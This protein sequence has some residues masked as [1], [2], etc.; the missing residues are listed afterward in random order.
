[1]KYRVSVFYDK[2]LLESGRIKLEEI[3][4][5]ATESLYTK[6]TKHLRK[7]IAKSIEEQLQNADSEELFL[8][9]DLETFIEQCRKDLNE[10]VKYL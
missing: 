8:V 7:S 6:I 1:M 9:Y 2:E 3:E 10:S 5:K 4:S